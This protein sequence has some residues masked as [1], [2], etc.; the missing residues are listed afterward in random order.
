M[1]ETH[2]SARSLTVFSAAII[3]CFSLLAACASTGSS[4]YR[5]SQVD[6]RPELQGCGSYSAPAREH[7]YNVELQFVVDETGVVKPGTVNPQP[8]R[9]GIGKRHSQQMLRQASNDV[10]SC[11]FSPAVLDGEPVPVRMTKRFYYP[12]RG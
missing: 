9:D 5:L 4:A 1:N 11:S 6:V 10:L 2:R 7:G 3:A 12:D 8:R